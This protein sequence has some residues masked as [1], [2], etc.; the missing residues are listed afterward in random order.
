MRIGYVNVFVSDLDRAM[1]FYG[2]LL[3]LELQHADR[4]F[5]Y[6]SYRAGEVRLGL[7]V[8]GEDQAELL[9]RHS[10]IG[11]CVDDLI[12]EHRRLAEAGV[13]FPM[14]PEEQ[15]WGGFMA[16]VADPDGNVHYLDQVPESA[17]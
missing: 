1:T 2:E 3:G 6:A 5:G 7:A 15:P 16:L 14:P 12:A 4:E 13:V 17:G 8:V 11:F 9:E 10:G